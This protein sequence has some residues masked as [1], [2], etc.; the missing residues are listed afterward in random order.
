MERLLRLRNKKQRLVAGLMSGTSLD[1]I[2]AALV[3]IEGSG[4]SCR[5]KQV[6]FKTVAYEQGLRQAI[7]KVCRQDSASVADICALNFTLGERFAAA[8]AEVCQEAG[9]DLGELDLIG[10]HG[11]TIWHIPGSSTLQIGEPA[12]IAERTGVITVADFRVRDVAAGGQGAPLVP[13]TEYVL[14]RD[15]RK[16]RL[17]QNI[18]GIANVTVLPA[19]CGPET[20]T[21]FDTGPGNM[22]ID[23][24]VS[25]ITGGRFA[26]DDAGRMAGCG[27]VNAGMLAELL[28]H[29]YLAQQPPKSTG[30]ELFG[31]PFA[32]GLV[33]KHLARGMSGEDI[34]A[35]LTA[36][37]AESI[38]GSYRLFILPYYTVDEVIVSG[39]GSHNQ[40]LLA[41]LRR[42]LPDIPVRT[43]EEAGFSSDAKEA[44]AFAILANETVSGRTNNLPAVTG[45]VKPVIM[46][47][48]LL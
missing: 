48:I 6:A 40:V 5:V 39:G 24:T 10:S 28:A 26:F 17:L 8:V 44:V 18:G 1:G 46:G 38:A 15:N 45:A 43:Q 42:Q 32:G 35:T 21:A 12:V 19:G 3:R 25:R 30:R 20:V 2:D 36:F 14:Y 9:V 27:R 29:P 37:T 31:E 13:Y 47:K 4:P 16:T 33:G 23:Y 41:M 22:L 34:V 7:L 11:Q